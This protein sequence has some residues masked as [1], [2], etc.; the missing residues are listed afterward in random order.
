MAYGIVIEMDNHYYKTPNKGKL[1]DLETGT[2]YTFMREGSSGVPTPW[3]VELYD[4]VSFTIDGST[5][6]GVTLVKKHVKGFVYS[7]TSGS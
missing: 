6:T 2:Q 5:A 3:N 4:V 7:Y 1:M